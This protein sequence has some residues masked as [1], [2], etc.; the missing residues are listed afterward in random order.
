MKRYNTSKDIKD[1]LSRVDQ[2]KHEEA[3]FTLRHSQAAR[4]VFAKM[5]YVRSFGSDDLMFWAEGMAYARALVSISSEVMAHH[6]WARSR[7]N[8]RRTIFASAPQFIML[9]EDLGIEKRVDKYGETHVKTID[10]WWTI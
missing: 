1:E 8:P 7:L 6:P 4:E 10:G 5:Q 3:L 9:A 2:R